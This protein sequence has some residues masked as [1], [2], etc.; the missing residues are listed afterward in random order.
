[1]AEQ[2]KYFGILRKYTSLCIGVFFCDFALHVGLSWKIYH[3]IT[4]SFHYNIKCAIMSL[5][6]KIKDTVKHLFSISRKMHDGEIFNWF[7]TLLEPYFHVFFEYLLSSPLFRLVCYRILSFKVRPPKF[8]WK[9]WK[10]CVHVVICSIVV[11]V[12]LHST[13][14]LTDKVY[15]M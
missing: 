14:K 7:F 15:T 8:N 1:M 10:L 5:F 9:K 13:E 6:L 4:S 2:G 3:R 12:Y 11:D